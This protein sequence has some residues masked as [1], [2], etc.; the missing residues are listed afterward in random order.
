MRGDGEVETEY[1]QVIQD[2]KVLQVMQVPQV[3]QVKKVVQAKKNY[4]INTKFAISSSHASYTKLYKSWNSCKYNE[5]HESI[6]RQQKYS[7]TWPT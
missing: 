1:M 6:V 3:M 5:H 7:V 2:M 4:A